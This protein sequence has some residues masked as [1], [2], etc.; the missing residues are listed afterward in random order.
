MI[1]NNVNKEDTEL[2]NQFPSQSHY[3]YE[4]IQ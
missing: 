1:Y 2:V 3:T 4:V